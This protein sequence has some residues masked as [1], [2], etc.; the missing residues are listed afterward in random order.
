MITSAHAPHRTALTVIAG[1]L[2]LAACG[3]V[4]AE[5]I[6]WGPTRESAV[7]AADDAAVGTGVLRAANYEE[8]PAPGRTLAVPRP[9]RLAPRAG[10]GRMHEHYVDGPPVVEELPVPGGLAAAR[11]GD[12]GPCGGEGC[13]HCTDCCGDWNSCGPVPV[14]CLLPRPNLQ[15]LELSGGV[16][17]FTGPLN[18]GASGSFGFYE[19]LNLGLP[20]CGDCFC[21][22]IGGL[23]TQSNF[24]GSF[25]AP[26]EVRNQMFLTAGLFRRVDWGLQAGVVFDYLHDE[27]DCEYDLAQLRGEL[28]WRY[29]G[30]H[31]LG[32]RFTVGV[33]DDVA[34]LNTPVIS[35]SGDSIA[36]QVRDTAV[37]V[38]DLFAFYY[39][40]QF[41]C[42]GEGRLF[43]GFTNHHQGLVGG[44]V[45]LPINDCWSLAADFLYVVPSDDDELPGF[46]EETWNVAVGVVWTPC[47]K[48][49]CG[50]N[51]C[52]P[53][54]DVANNGTFATRL[55]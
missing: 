42:G 44:D 38:N 7:V 12:C 3:P 2:L 26:E 27:W 23:W 34:P 51:Y 36:L 18:R 9:S 39:R 43:G 4:R 45:R 24:D 47:A 53:L 31:E 10:I 37:E 29:C 16:H 17:G 35:S 15:N 32:F 46:T 1:G 5:T 20:L 50:P 14:C 6:G 8:I 30:C 19:G 25:I 33:D 48:P 13:G 54:F 11:A 49:G 52:R 28:G 55:K 21:G 40:R 22:Q 41:A